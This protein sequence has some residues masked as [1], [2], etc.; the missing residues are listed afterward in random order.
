MLKENIKKAIKLESKDAIQRF[1]STGYGKRYS[2]I[3]LHPFSVV[4]LDGHK[5]DIL[6][7]VELENKD[8]EIISRIAT[9]AWLLA[10]ID[11]ATRTILGYSITANENYNQTDVLAAIKNSIEPK[12]KMVFSHEGFKYPVN[13]GYHTLALPETQWAL[14]DNIMLDNAKAHLA[15]DVVNKLVN[16]LKCNVNF[17]S[18]ATPETKGIVERLFKTLEENGYRRIVSTTG[19]NIKD[20]RRKNAEQDAMKYS[21]TYL[22]IEEMIEYFI[23]I[24]NN[25][26]HS[27]LDNETPLQRMQ[28]RILD[29]GMQPCIANTDEKDI[30]TNL[31]N[32]ILTRIIRGGYGSGKRPIHNVKLEPAQ[33]NENNIKEY[34][35]ENNGYE[36]YKLGNDNRKVSYD[37]YFTIISAPATKRL[38]IDLYLQLSSIHVK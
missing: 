10:I 24:Y 16:R 15:K 11:V 25:S 9:R 33:V 36:A 4:Q 35:I 7:T 38:A 14:F 20:K 28:R 19:S 27:A 37:K 26:P 6:Y 8:G 21:V 2:T 22:D 23:S 12:R 34:V 32:V 13:G 29:S 5:I 3:P 30:I 18:V 31:T 17:G 1:N